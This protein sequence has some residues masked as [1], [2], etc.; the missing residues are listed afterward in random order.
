MKV[1]ALASILIFLTC[2]SLWGTETTSDSLRIAAE[3]GDA[4]AQYELGLNYENGYYGYTRDRDEAKLWWR[5]AAEQGYV[6]AQSSLGSLLL[7]QDDEE[8]VKEGLN[9]LHLASEQGDV[10]SM[11]KLGYHYEDLADYPEAYYWYLLASALGGFEGY[12]DRIICQKNLL[13]SEIDAARKRAEAWYSAYMLKT[14][15]ESWW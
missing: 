10:Q 9:W 2:L 15:N 6:P 14:Y 3:Q 11:S 1:L 5:K 13:A 7:R 4:I 12:N 8:Q